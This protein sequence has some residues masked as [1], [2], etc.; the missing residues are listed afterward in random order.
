[1]LAETTSFEDF[2]ATVQPKL[3]QAFAARYGQAMGLTRRLRPL[4]MR[5]STGIGSGPWTILLGICI[6]LVGVGREVSGDQCRFS[7][8][9]PHEAFHM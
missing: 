8:T 1:V 3:R 7:L 5:G 9:C 4:G 2:C 6:A